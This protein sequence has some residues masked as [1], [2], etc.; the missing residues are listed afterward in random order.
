ME[1]SALPLR[2]PTP[3]QNSLPITLPFLAEKTTLI[4]SPSGVH[5]RAAV[6]AGGDADDVLCDARAL[7]R[8][9][10]GARR[11]GNGLRRL[12]ARVPRGDRR[13]A[14]ACLHA[15]GGWRLA[16][17][18]GPPPLRGCAS[19]IREPRASRPP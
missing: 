10:V 16:R 9:W 13:A 7:P 1:F 4:T 5:R 12:P 3:C 2:L 8:G 15:D 14:G 11:G 6:G 18:D 17:G 19:R